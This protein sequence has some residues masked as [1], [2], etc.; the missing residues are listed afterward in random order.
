MWHKSPLLFL[1][2]NFQTCSICFTTDTHYG[3]SESST[4]VLFCNT[5]RTW[6][7]WPSSFW[8]HSELTGYPA[9]FAERVFHFYSYKLLNLTVDARRK[10]CPS[11]PPDLSSE[12]K[13][14]S[15]DSLFS[16]S[17]SCSQSPYSS[18][19]WNVKLFLTRKLRASK[20]KIFGLCTPLRNVVSS[21]DH[22]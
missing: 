14:G 4:Y 5:I 8:W 1:C 3:F 15:L 22:I 16:L 6:I 11:R 21:W 9:S 13:G 18:L 7:R 20:K 2:F 12:D 19:T 10:N 17:L